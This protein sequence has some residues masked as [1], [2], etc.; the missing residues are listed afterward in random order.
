MATPMALSV[1]YRGSANRAPSM[2]W[3]NSRLEATPPEQS[4]GRSGCSF[5]AASLTRY[6]RLAAVFRV[7]LAT[8]G[9]VPGQCAA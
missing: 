4:T 1:E 5:R 7:N 3:R 8:S 2:V 9:L 6:T